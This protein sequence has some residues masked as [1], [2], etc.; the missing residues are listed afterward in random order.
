MLLVDATVYIEG[1]S[2]SLGNHTDSFAG[3]R[4]SD[5]L[6]QM[7]FKVVVE[8]S[9]RKRVLPTASCGVN[10]II[11]F[12]CFKKVADAHFVVLLAAENKAQLVIDHLNSVDEPQL[13]SGVHLIEQ[14]QGRLEVLLAVGRFTQDKIVLAEHE[15]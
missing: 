2:L 9:V 4:R 7:V 11:Y 1:E 13:G 14:A 15:V 6:E 3:L 5:L 12:F 10:Q 8:V